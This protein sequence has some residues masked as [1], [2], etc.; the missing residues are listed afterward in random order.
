V[1][2]F[3]ALKQKR[4]FVAGCVLAGGLFKFQLVLPFLVPF[5]FKKQTRTVL[6][7]SCAT[8]LIL[9]SASVAVT[10]IGG[11][12]QYVRMLLL[13]AD[14]PRMAPGVFPWMMPNWRGLV[15]S[16]LGVWG[17][18]MVVR[19]V[20]AIGSLLLIGFAS[21]SFRRWWTE[22]TLDLLFSMNLVIAILASYHTNLHDL[23][24]L[25]LPLW[26]VGNHLAAQSVPLRGVAITV[27]S[28][29]LAT[30]L[31]FVCTI[32]EQVYWLGL[33]LLAA[34]CMISIQTSAQWEKFAKCAVETAS[35]AVARTRL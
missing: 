11:A 17:G 15:T 21:Y 12:V 8:A 23:T 22:G 9:V 20:I 5:A 29:L 14:S 10:G 33:I 6:W 18:D 34:L 31:Y 3:V 26:L 28:V 27:G 13:D 35:C 2:A 7:G 30:P 16:T 4:F 1:L 19:T 24:M 25:L 32:S